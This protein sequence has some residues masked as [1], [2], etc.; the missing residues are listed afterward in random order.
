MWFRHVTTTT[1]LAKDK[2][3][4]IR[5]TQSQRRRNEDEKGRRR[6]RRRRR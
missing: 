2:H 6:M 4:G 5:D 1:H 3:Q